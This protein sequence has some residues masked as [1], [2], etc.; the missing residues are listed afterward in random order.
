MLQ[1]RIFLQSESWG[2]GNC[3]TESYIFRSTLAVLWSVKGFSNGQVGRKKTAFSA[4]MAISY[5]KRL[6]FFS[7]ETLDF[8]GF[9]ISM[10]TGYH[11]L[12]TL[13][14][15]LEAMR[16]NLQISQ[17]VQGKLRCQKTSSM[18]FMSFLKVRVNMRYTNT[19]QD[20]TIKVRAHQLYNQWFNPWFYGIF[21]E[22]LVDS[23]GP[24]PWRS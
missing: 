4:W 17:A 24:L 21:D 19:N 6:M 15:S 22:E 11:G 14:S 16:A 3:F 1:N 8:Y 20:I 7:I 9:S 12:L 13:R 2:H 5:P 18:S 10:C 23:S